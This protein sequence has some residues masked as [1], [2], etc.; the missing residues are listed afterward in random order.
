MALFHLVEL[1]LENKVSD[2]CQENRH[3]ANRQASIGTWEDQK[4]YENNIF[5]LC[6][7]SYLQRISYAFFS[8]NLS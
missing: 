6:C 3:Q 5:N 8:C 4:G 2:V 7:A 1:K